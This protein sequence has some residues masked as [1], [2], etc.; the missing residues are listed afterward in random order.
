MVIL[1]LE[2]VIQDDYNII[3]RSVI[4]EPIKQKQLTEL[5]EAEVDKIM[6]NVATITTSIHKEPY[7]VF[8]EIDY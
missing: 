4:T 5:T 1:P 7:L 6:E 8:V 2:I 3:T